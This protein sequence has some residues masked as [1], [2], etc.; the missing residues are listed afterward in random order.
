MSAL[1][2]S[3]AAARFVAGART[4]DAGAGASAGGAA[5]AAGAEQRGGAPPPADGGDGAG[6]ERSGPTLRTR[7]DHGATAA[8]AVAAEAEAEAEARAKEAAEPKV[9]VEDYCVRCR[10]LHSYPGN[11]LLLC[12][13]DGCNAAWHLH[14]LR[15][16][17][18]MVPTGKWYCPT[19]ASV[20]KKEAAREEA[21]SIEKVHSGPGDRP[22][23]PRGEPPRRAPEGSPDE[24]PRGEPPRGAP[25]RAPSEPRPRMRD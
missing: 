11:E 20:R 7:G 15:P 24:S 2:A 12:D 4:G 13:G 1:S 10:E 3:S 6:S 17:L 9:Y 14:C 16:K 8:A 19:C 18:L 5:S 22:K 25:R 23:S 21:N